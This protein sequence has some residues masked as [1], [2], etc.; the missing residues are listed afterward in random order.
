MVD[1]DDLSRY[2][3][4]PGLERRRQNLDDSHTLDMLGEDLVCHGRRQSGGA[5]ILCR[6]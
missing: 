1:G 5:H 3:W 4:D 2:D 6:R